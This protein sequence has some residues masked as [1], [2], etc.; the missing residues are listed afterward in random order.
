MFASPTILE[1][2]SFKN[3]PVRQIHQ[4]EEVTTNVLLR[5]VLAELV[6]ANSLK[7]N[8]LAAIHAERV[9]FNNAGHI[10][11]YWTICLGS[12]G[13]CLSVQHADWFY[14]LV[15]GACYGGIAAI[16]QLQL[17]QPFFG[18]GLSVTLLH[19]AVSSLMVFITLG[20]LLCVMGS[21]KF[22]R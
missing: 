2:D 12:S 19:E 21:C 10:Y 5:K 15:Q 13:L 22:S 18:L 3:V 6:K 14:F 4:G 20:V 17:L 1:P 11:R 9:I 8:P 16:G 7:E